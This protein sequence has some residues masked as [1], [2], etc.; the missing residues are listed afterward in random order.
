MAPIKCK[1]VVVLIDRDMEHIATAVFAHELPILEAAH[2]EG[3]VT[4]VRELTPAPIE[5]THDEWERLSRLYAR[6]NA[7]PL[8]AAYPAGEQQ[9]VEYI[10]RD[11]VDGGGKAAKAPAQAAA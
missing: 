4:V 1:R 6:R 3:S 5:S 11:A 9:L 10:A 8:R 2:G 7:N